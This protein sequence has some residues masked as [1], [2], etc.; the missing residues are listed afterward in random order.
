M[1]KITTMLRKK[2]KSINPKIKDECG[3][4]GISNNNDASALTA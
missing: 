3:V 2:F 1:K 4:F